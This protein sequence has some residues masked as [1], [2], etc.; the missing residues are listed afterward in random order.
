LRIQSPK[1]PQ[2]VAKALPI[3]VSSTVFVLAIAY[4]VGMVAIY[5]KMDLIDWHGWDFGQVVAFLLWLPTLLE[6]GNAILSKLNA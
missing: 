1:I 6:L 3:T 5:Q 4:Y 2:S